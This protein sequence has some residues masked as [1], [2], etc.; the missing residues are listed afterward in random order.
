MILVSGDMNAHIS[1]FAERQNVRGDLLMELA[2]RNQLE[3]LNLSSKCKGRYTR[4]NEHSKSV[5][6]Y[7]LCNQAMQNLVREMEIDEDQ[8]RSQISDHC[9][10][11][12]V[13]EIPVKDKGEKREKKFDQ[14]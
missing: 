6:D 13:L 14:S 11:N 7:V 1:Q 10:I 12:V 3:I 2:E 5:I 9:M 8:L 4:K